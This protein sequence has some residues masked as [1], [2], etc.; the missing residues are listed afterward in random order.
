[1]LYKVRMCFENIIFWSLGKKNKQSDPLECLWTQPG[2]MRAKV[3]SPGNC[4][5]CLRDQSLAP[6]WPWGRDPSSRVSPLL[7][8]ST[9]L[10]T[11]LRWASEKAAGCSL[12][13]SAPNDGEKMQDRE[14]KIKKKKGRKQNLRDWFEHVR[15]W[16]C[17]VTLWLR[18][19]P[20][21]ELV[22]P[23]FPRDSLLHCAP[24]SLGP[25]NV[26][27]DFQRCFLGENYCLHRW[28]FSVLVVDC[29]GTGRDSCH[30]EWCNVI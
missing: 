13:H 8:C 12:T 1:M 27:I 30:W 23:V 17:G 24:C 9:V 2:A 26:F 5:W 11:N 21:Q 25:D 15:P 16:H 19:P 28:D 10:V 22:V 3:I 7:C 18:S 4:L 20:A 14:K 6:A 29:W